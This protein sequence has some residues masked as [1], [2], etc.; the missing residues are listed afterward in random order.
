MTD[1]LLSPRANPVL[2]KFRAALAEMYGPR[3][4]RVVLYGSRARGDAEADSDYDVAVFLKDLTNRIAE[5]NRIAL[6]VSDILSETGIVIH[7]MPFAAGNYRERT[8]LMHE[9]QREGLEL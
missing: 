2:A 3:L 9:I 6:A 8:M 1:A 7:A 4:E 5:S